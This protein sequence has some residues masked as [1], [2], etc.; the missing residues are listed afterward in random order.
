MHEI[1]IFFFSFISRKLLSTFMHLLFSL[2]S[3]QSNSYTHKPKQFT[4]IAMQPDIFIQSFSG[5]ARLS[6]MDASAEEAKTR[7]TFEAYCRHAPRK[8]DFL[9]IYRLFPA[10]CG[11]FVK[12]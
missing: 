1:N 6:V 3:S 10:F 2:A 9:S 8:S 5:A 11:S 4:F 7:A 12:L